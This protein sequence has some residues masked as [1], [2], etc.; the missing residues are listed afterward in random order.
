MPPPFVQQIRSMAAAMA[1]LTRQNHREINQRRQH[2]ERCVEGQAWSQEDRKGE[3][4]EHEN[5]SRG[6]ASHR[7]PY[8]ERETDKIRGTMDEM[9]ENMRSTSHVDDL[10]HRTD[11]PFIASINRHPLPSKFKM[12]SLDF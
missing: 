10:V 3:N 6:T 8:L 2:N 9:S 11:S 12:P 4:V 1:E 7:V 5:H